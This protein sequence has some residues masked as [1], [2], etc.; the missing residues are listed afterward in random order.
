MIE[1]LIAGHCQ[2]DENGPAE[3]QDVFERRTSNSIIK[4]TKMD[5]QRFKTFSK[6]ERAIPS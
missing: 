3:I 2:E 6:D 4:K 1:N 5:L